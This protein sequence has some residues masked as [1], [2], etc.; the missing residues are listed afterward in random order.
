MKNI[1]T[2]HLIRHAKSS[3]DD[4]TLADRDRPLN[5]RGICTS[6]MMARPVHDAGCHFEQVFC[7]PAVR[8][9]ST[10][11]LIHQSLPEIKFRWKTEKALYTFESDDVLR[12][13]RKLD[14]EMS[15]I[16]IVGHNPALTDFCHQLSGV[17]LNNIPTCGYVKLV[18]VSPCQWKKINK[19]TFDLAVFL[20]PKRLMRTAD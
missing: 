18:S 17:D 2:I 13:C 6:R 1:K 12:W 9:Q 7:S 5:P 15:D 11:E 20:K 14:D 10:I 8:A 4:P 19:K 3:W 16:V